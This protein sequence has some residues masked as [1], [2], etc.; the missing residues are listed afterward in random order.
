MAVKYPFMHRKNTVQIKH[1]TLSFSVLHLYFIEKTAKKS[2]F[3]LYNGYCSVAEL[4]L[5]AANDEVYMSDGFEG[6]ADG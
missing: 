3:C 1:N 4:L 6:Y 2:C 5:H